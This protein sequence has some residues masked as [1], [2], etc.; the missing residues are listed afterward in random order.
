MKLF[1]LRA[2]TLRLFGVV[3]A[4]AGL[5]SACSY[6]RIAPEGCTTTYKDVSYAKDVVPIF[7]SNC[8][9]CHDAAHYQI[10]FPNGASSAMNMESF[11][12][13][14]AWTSPTTGIG[15]VS[16]MVGCIR[17]DSGF[18]PMP[19]DG[20]GQLDACQVALIKTWVDEGAKNN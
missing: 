13:V 5:L 12:S 11:S 20:N 4:F 17:H 10:P 3:A 15:G 16:Y 18:N 8:Y 7:K 9:R 2:N 19:Y 6:T 1:T 14:S